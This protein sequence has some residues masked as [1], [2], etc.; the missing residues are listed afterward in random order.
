MWSIQQILSIVSSPCADVHL[1]YPHFLNTDIGEMWPETFVIILAEKSHFNLMNIFSLNL[2]GGIDGIC[3][4]AAFGDT[5]RFGCQRVKQNDIEHPE[6][7]SHPQAS[8]HLSQTDGSNR[9]TGHSVYKSAD[10]RPA[11]CEDNQGLVREDGEDGSGAEVVRQK[12]RI[13]K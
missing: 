4:R 3:Y 11:V 12:L 9:H 7:I 6:A 1:P 5:E 8:T 10:W 2:T 13:Q